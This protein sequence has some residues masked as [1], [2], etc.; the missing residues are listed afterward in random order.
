MRR[1]GDRH[2]GPLRPCSVPV[3]LLAALALLLL[4]PVAGGKVRHAR[5]AGASAL[6]RGALSVVCGVRL[7]CGPALW[8]V[9]VACELFGPGIA[10]VTPHVL[11][12]AS[13]RKARARQQ[14]VRFTQHDC[15]CTGANGV[16]LAQVLAIP[17]PGAESHLYVM[18][19]I[20]DELAARGHEVMVTPSLFGNTTAALGWCTCFCTQVNNL[21][22]M[23]LWRCSK[24]R[25]WT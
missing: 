1:P 12:F 17:M 8:Y 16:H 7:A 14:V 2:Q 19:T 24:A 4:R 20:T 15:C 10:L 11:A 9:R 21:S 25:A 3:L 22:G 6:P 23:P 5:A 13:T 18:S